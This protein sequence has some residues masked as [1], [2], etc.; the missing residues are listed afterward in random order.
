MIA[1]G[2]RLV[3]RR[4][5]WQTKRYF[6][7]RAGPTGD[8][9]GIASPLKQRTQATG[10]GNHSE[11]PREALLRAHCGCSY[12]MTKRGVTPSAFKC[13]CM[14]MFFLCMHATFHCI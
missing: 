7:S 10:S 11:R 3:L 8:Q 5:S 9:E 13:D 12:N 14:L 6:K 1:G 4:G 2:A